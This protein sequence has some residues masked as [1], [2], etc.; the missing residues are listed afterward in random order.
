MNVTSEKVN[1][2]HSVSHSHK[3]TAP[4]LCAHAQVSQIAQLS[5]S[6]QVSS[7]DSL[8]NQN[9][10]DIPMSRYSQMVKFYYDAPRSLTISV[11]F[12]DGDLFHKVSSLHFPNPTPRSSLVTQAVCLPGLIGEVHLDYPRGFHLQ[13][14]SRMIDGLMP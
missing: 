6:Y 14:M 2:Q 3:H 1:H 5:V 7:H 9:H 10:Q 11:S 12:V 4:L 13:G 8:W